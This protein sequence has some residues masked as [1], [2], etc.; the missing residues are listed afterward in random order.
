MR[1]WRLAM[2]AGVLIAG[3]AS[4]A[5]ADVTGFL[6]LNTTPSVR[7]A[8]GFAIGSGFTI[9]GFEFEYSSASRDDSELAPS[10]TTGM[11]NVLLQTPI[12]IHRAQLYFTVGGGVYRERLNDRVVDTSFG[13]NVGGGVKITLV[14]P[15]RLRLDYRSTRLGH[16]A[17]YSPA[18]R[19]YAGLNLKF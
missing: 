1:S 17:L 5:H 6:G 3:S 19:V 8:K 7:P 2:L 9:V 18:H 11:G 16:D 14:G 13:T 15:L 10:L 12:T 4:P